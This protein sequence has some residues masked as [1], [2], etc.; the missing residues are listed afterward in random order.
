MDGFTACH[1][2]S[3]LPHNR[4]GT[5]FQ[6]ETGTYQITQ[7]L[8]LTPMATKTSQLQ[9]KNC[10]SIVAFG[11]A[12]L[13]FTSFPTQAQTPNP[14]LQ[15]IHTESQATNGAIA[16][17]TNCASCHANDLRGN[18][19]SPGL[20]GVGFLFLWEGRPLSELFAKMRTE[21]PTDRPGSLPTTTYIDLLAF[22]LSRNG[23]PVGDI[24]L[25]P[26]MLEAEDLLIEAP[27]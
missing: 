3:Y 12:A 1:A 8:N 20:V 25:A 5:I 6:S 7:M 17:Q 16:Y 19:N 24:A 2:Q 14:L 13:L 23:Y 26:G 10:T 22:L 27:H 21:M 4:P 9:F 15:G 11:I 18:S